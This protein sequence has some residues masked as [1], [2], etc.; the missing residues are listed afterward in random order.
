M[1]L[2]S[3]IL[4]NSPKKMAHFY[5]IFFKFQPNWTTNERTI[6][7]PIIT[8]C[9]TMPISTS[10]I[11]MSFSQQIQCINAQIIYYKIRF[12]ILLSK[13]RIRRLC[14]ETDQSSRVESLNDN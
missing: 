10:F 9:I 7:T 11:L 3:E 6:K 13:Y 12:I 1:K 2:K 5:I 14:L 8:T 4:A